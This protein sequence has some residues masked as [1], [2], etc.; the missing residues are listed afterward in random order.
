MLYGRRGGILKLFPIRRR[1]FNLIRFLLP[2]AA[3]LL[4]FRIS[5]L[6]TE[7]TRVANAINQAGIFRCAPQ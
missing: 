1:I 6:A 4:F 5:H 3:T 2:A 7:Q